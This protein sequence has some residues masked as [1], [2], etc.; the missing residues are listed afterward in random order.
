MTPPIYTQGNY[1]V[2]TGSAQVAHNNNSYLELRI[3]ALQ[4]TRELGYELDGCNAYTYVRTNENVSYRILYRNAWGTAPSL[5]KVC[6]DKNGDGDFGDAG[7]VNSMS[8]VTPGTAY[9]RGIIYSYTTQFTEAPNPTNV[10]YYFWF[11]D[12]PNTTVTERIYAP[13]VDIV[14]PVITMIYPA[15][16]AFVYSIQPTCRWSAVDALTPITNY[17]VKIDEA[18]WVSVG[19][20]TNYIVPFI[21]REGL[22]TWQVR[23]TDE[24]GNTSESALWPFK[25]SD[26]GPF[27]TIDNPDH[28]ITTRY[29]NITFSGT[30]WSFWN[31]QKVEL[32]PY[33]TLCTGSSVWWRTEALLIG[34]NNVSAIATDLSGRRGNADVYI[35]HDPG[36]PADTTPPVVWIDQPT[37]GST[38]A[39]ATI[40]FTGR[41]YDNTALVDVRVDGVLARG[42]G[43]WKLERVVGAGLSSHM[44]VARDVAGNA[45]TQTVTVFY[46]SAAPYDAQPP[47]LT[48]LSPMNG[49]T[50]PVR[51]VVLNGT[52]TDNSGVESVKANGT[53]VE[54]VTA[55]RLPMRLSEGMNVISL[56]ARDWNGNASS[57]SFTNWYF[58]G[59]PV[60]TI[61]PT[62]TIDQPAN[63]TYYN[64][65]QTIGVRGTAADNVNVARVALNSET[66]S[67]VT[68]WQWTRQLVNGSNVLVA[69]A[70]D[71]SGNSAATSAVCIVDTIAPSGMFV[72]INGGASYTTNVNVVVTLAASDTY[73]SGMQLAEN[74]AFTGATWVPY[75]GATNMALSGGDGTK[76]L[77]ARFRDLAGNF[78]VA[79]S[80]S[81]VLD[82]TRPICVSVAVNRDPIPAGAITA[83][84]SFADNMTG[85]DNAVAPGVYFISE[86]GRSG[87]FSQIAYVGN[88][89]TGK[90]TVLAGDDGVAYVD[91]LN[92]ADKAGNVML[93]AYQ[94]TNFLIDTSAPGSGS[95]TINAGAA[96][97]NSSN[98]TLAIY[99]EDVLAMQMMVGNEPGF[100]GGVWE[101]YATSKAWTL[102]GG[103]G[104]RAAYVKF[105]DALLNESTAAVASIIVDTTAPASAAV[106]IN[107]GALY[108]SNL[109]VTLS[110]SAS[111]VNLAQ[112]RYSEDAAF[113]GALWMAYSGITNMTLTSGDG[114][115]T[116]Y[117]Q[118]RDAAG[119]TSAV[120]QASIVLDLTRPVVAGIAV[121]A[122]PI[123]AGAITA[124]VTFADAPAGMNTAATPFVYFVTAG[125]RTGTL[126]MIAYTGSVWRGSGTLLIGDDGMA[127]VD[128]LNAADKAGNVMLPA[129]HATNFF[130]DTTVPTNISVVINGGAAYTSNRT[131]MLTIHAEDA[132][133]IVM[134]IA[135]NPSFTGAAW[136]PYVTATNWLLAANDGART[137]YVKFRD[138][139]LN[140]SL[141]V[142]DSIIVDTTPPS[143]ES[144]TIN[145]GA[146]YTSNRL[147]IL[148]LSAF[149]LYLADMRVSEQADFIGAGWQAYQASTNWQLSA[150]DGSKTIYAQFRDAAGNIGAV[151]QASIVYDGTAPTVLSA[152]P[153]PDPAKVGAVTITVTFVD[154]D[155]GMDTAVPPTVYFA[156]MGNRTQTVTQTS[157]IGDQWAGIGA[158]QPGDNGSASIHV[159]NA[160]D[161][162]GNVMA[163]NHTAGT[164]TIDT[165]APSNVYAYINDNAVFTSSRNVTI[166]NR[167]IGA[168]LVDIANTSTFAVFSTTNYMPLLPWQL[169]DRE[170][171]NTVYLRYRDDANNTAY[172]NDWIIL[173]RTAPSGIGVSINGGAGYTSKT[174]VTLTLSASDLYLADMRVANAPSFAGAS[175]VPYASATNWTL[176]AGDGTKTVYAQFRDA[177]G[178]TSAVAQAS[179]ILDTTPPSGASVSINGGAGYTSNTAVTLSL[180]ASDAYLADMRFS[181]N[182]DFAGAG[183]QAYA[184]SAPFTLAPI[185]GTRTVYA[186]FRDA[187][188]NTSAVAQASIVLDTVRPGLVSL[189]MATDPA[190]AGMVTAIV[191][192]VD[193]TAG[194]DT[195]ALPTMYFATAAGRTGMFGQV[196]F[197]GSVWRAAAT[198]LA[199]DD[200]VAYLD[201]MAAKDKAGNVMLPVYRATNFLVVTTAPTNRSIV[202]NNGATYA[203]TALVSLQIH[204]EDVLAMQM[205]LANDAGFSGGVWESYA[206][207]KAWTLAAGDGTKTV[208]VK[209][210]DALLNESAAVSDSIILDTT[211]PSG[212]SVSINGGAGYTSNT[213]VTLSL[214]ASDAYLADMRFSEN[215]DFSG[216]GWQTYAASAPFTLAPIEGTR[217]VYAQF[218]DAAGNTSAVAQASIVYDATR[219]VLGSIG[220]SPNPSTMGAVTVTVTFTDTPAG[221]DTTRQPIASFTTASSRIGNF[222]Q[223][224]F[225]G[226][227]WMGAANVVLGDDGVAWVSVQS[228]ADRAGNL[229]LPLTNVV[230]FT[231][232]TRAPSNQTVS[233]N[234]GA[235]YAN[236]SQVT[237]TIYAEDASAMQMMVG[238][239]PG[240]SG[241][242]WEA[243]ATAKA[244]TLAAGD[245][246]RAVYVTFRDALGNQSGAVSNTIIVDTSA[247]SNTSIIINSGA[248]YAS[249]STVQLTLH[250]DDASPIE[251]MLANAA[252]FTGGVWQSYAANRPWQLSA[253][254]GS[255]A[256]Y[257][258][259]RDIAGNESVPVSGTI[260]LDTTAPSNALVVINGGASATSN[261]NVSLALNALDVHLSD[262]RIANNAAFAGANWL[263]FV[264]S[265]NWAFSGGDGV[266][267]VYAQFRDAAGN[268][269]DTAQT[270]IIFDTTRPL[271]AAAWGQPDPAK[272]G[273][274]TVMVSFTETGA[275]MDHDANPS[276]YLTTAGGQTRTISELSYTGAV[277]AGH[278]FIEEG[279]DGPAVIH[280]NS[281]KD[282]VGNVMLTND[283]AGTVTLDTVAPTNYWMQIN[284]GAAFASNRVV[285]ITNDTV[286]ASM[287]DVATDLTFSNAFTTNY[288]AVFRWSLPPVQGTNAVYARYRDIAGNSCQTGSWIIL[289]TIPPSG[290]I[291]V[292]NG[293][294]SETTNKLVALA[295][296][297]N[298]PY[299]NGMIVGNDLLFSGST[300]TNFAASLAWML[301][302]PIGE[303]K[304][305]YA[306]FSDMAGWQSSVASNSID[307]VPEPSLVVTLLIAALSFGNKRS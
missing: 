9:A 260:L 251:M 88:G 109:V 217:T 139:V 264:A 30:A 204:A 136:V 149:D 33:S 192:F 216:A 44:V 58:T 286:G 82:E 126:N 124:A 164:I 141:A 167:T 220:V 175:W 160:A 83:A 31:V 132:L 150:A 235:V 202:I 94:I 122:N 36:A 228:A 274:L 14:P 245:G 218:R 25:V 290:A 106:S 21:L 123:K 282:A 47:V 162:A 252:S 62:I 180:S 198:I 259:F 179:I 74:A 15:S 3:V 90:G 297:A 16:N 194:M 196:L 193:A 129:L 210:R 283:A 53:D 208:Y 293:G 108:T 43:V 177:A 300:W 70:F 219:P 158:I 96:F 19:A 295:L 262:M 153:T 172:T 271:V 270:N 63:P 107:G 281:A 182:A 2:R 66:V 119:N 201:V 221:M 143:G 188:G 244:W 205:M 61:P 37:A 41:A 84:V 99:A 51:Q 87:G 250:A 248:A 254:D 298:D 121:S 280:V 55:W 142:S 151:A 59:L 72:R 222:S 268:V 4:Y 278:G 214:S 232:D 12:A 239:D 249:N 305:V 11:S 171:T 146:A 168:T 91:V 200:G 166:S 125:N 6:I 65:P 115:K 71:N 276:V 284:E 165:L 273:I 35:Y 5:A 80:N 104:L 155:A 169:D 48:V 147:V 103:D 213:A 118:F 292:I 277:W 117:A 130:V 101:P 81:V 190:K 227:T 189:I 97:A 176:I 102:A 230:S 157:Y 75:A 246:T 95:V 199:G 291:V 69:M 17:Q 238:N 23:A 92:A 184:A 296:S 120:A 178:N 56:V 64:A 229:L 1:Y 79:I 78:S 289:D 34:D 233:I 209:F 114:T 267:T 288:T 148:D 67:G 131:V 86:G 191:T 98:V 253:G 203:N 105:R 144:V 256:V 68:A 111:D 156:T 60:D 261:L 89:W 231:V 32:D 38:S 85:M 257:C 247:P 240:F 197:T 100:G 211:P 77:Y 128:V 52:A 7:E 224:S 226:N 159:L 207:S 265:I 170:G 46:W 304:T 76:T 152:I 223:L 73:L 127:N 24:M 242:V 263:A 258:K 272:S 241:G 303:T 57:I 183:W 138:A 285:R 26:Q 8:K 212:A 154:A 13:I 266:K 135:N 29:A 18:G 110:L 28:T 301:P 49:A 255:K 225:V 236:S 299:L 243:Y 45:A 234:A 306:K 302:E 145:G 54:G 93:P 140:E 187:A 112:M 237:L 173:D 181:E 116:V 186:Q 174:A 307:L 269:S 215:A 161:R 40:I 134:M 163:A 42:L 206:T 287:V 50:S 27:V 275:G 195:T 185:E 113:V 133:G 137:V 294:E 22:H 20:A 10:S 279:D 39:V